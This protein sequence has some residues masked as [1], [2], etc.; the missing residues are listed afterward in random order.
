MAALTP[1]LPFSQERSEIS[2]QEFHAFHQQELSRYPFLPQYL[3]RKNPYTGE[4]IQSAADYDAYLREHSYHAL[5]DR[6][7]RRIRSSC[8]D[9]LSRHESV[10][11]AVK[12]ENAAAAAYS[13]QVQKRLRTEAD[14]AKKTSRLWR[15][16][17]LA[18]IVLSFGFHIVLAISSERVVE[19][20]GYQRGFDD[21]QTQ[22]NAEAYQSGYDDGY[23]N[24]HTDGYDKAEHEHIE[25]ISIGYDDGYREGYIDGYEDAD[26][27]LPPEETRAPRST[28]P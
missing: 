22:G 12:K 27:G 15:L 24:G 9:A 10:I 23:D 3:N 2:P 28:E 18:A 1:E 19:A 25:D 4:P 13:L 14:D 21:A 26:S 16:L 7:C 17:A 6:Q 20:R 8:E 11:A 5:C